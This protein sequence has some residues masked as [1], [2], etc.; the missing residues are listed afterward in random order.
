MTTYEDVNNEWRRALPLSP[1]TTADA[2]RVASRLRMKFARKHPLAWWMKRRRAW[3]NTK[4]VT[5]ILRNN[6]LQRTVHDM[7]HW[8][9]DARHK[10]KLKDH[11]HVHAALELEMIRFVIDAGL[12]LPVTPA[13]RPVVPELERVEAAIKRWTTKARRAATALKK[14]ER[15]RKR[16]LRTQ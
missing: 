12:H 2:F 15:K 1:I 7:A 4:T 5:G 8:A 10:G 16:L 3:A 6:G 13:T 14:L 11:S 9:H